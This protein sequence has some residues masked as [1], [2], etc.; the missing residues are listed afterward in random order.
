MNNKS[1][2]RLFKMADDG[3]LFVG[4]LSF[5]TEEPSLEEAFSKYGDIVK[6]K[7]VIKPDIRMLIIYSPS[8]LH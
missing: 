2:L 3:K 4:G 7:I 8:R 1:F 5:D 6:G